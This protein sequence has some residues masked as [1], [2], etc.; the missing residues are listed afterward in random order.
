MR[1]FFKVR[2]NTPNIILSNSDKDYCKRVISLLYEL[3]CIRVPS[4]HFRRYV[5][6]KSI[7]FCFHFSSHSHYAV[8]IMVHSL[9]FVNDLLRVGIDIVNQ[10]LVVHE[11]SFFLG[12]YNLLLYC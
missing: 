5:C 9:E 10:P 7:M 11:G 4:N 3:Q 1:N 6:W 12:L 8:K 2:C